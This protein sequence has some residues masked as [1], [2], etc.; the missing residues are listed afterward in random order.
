MS[1]PSSK[2]LKKK[3]LIAQ[4]SLSRIIFQK[5]IDLQSSGTIF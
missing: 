5:T 4:T 1:G 3:F 2:T